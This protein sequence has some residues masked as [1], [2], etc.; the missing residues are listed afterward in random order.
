[1]TSIK[2]TKDKMGFFRLGTAQYARLK[3]VAR[4]E[5]L[6]VSDIVRR[7]IVDYLTRLAA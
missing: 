5:D 2:K 7:A 1:M 4:K 6:T 3:A